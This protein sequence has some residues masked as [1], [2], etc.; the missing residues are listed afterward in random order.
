MQRTGE[1]AGVNLAPNMQDP[2]R[3]YEE[4]LAAHEGLTNEQSFELNAR[5]LM[6][7]ANQVGK[8]DILSK[9]IELARAS[10]R[11]DGRS[12]GD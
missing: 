7:L 3:F 8:H 10:A 4:L 1:A 2:D 12:A 9:C 6:L 11:P 5:L